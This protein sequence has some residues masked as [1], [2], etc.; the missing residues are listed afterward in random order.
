MKFDKILDAFMFREGTD[1]ETYESM[2]P[3][4]TTGSVVWGV[5]L[6]T[7]IIILLSLFIIEQ[8]DL[9]EYWWLSA[10]AIWAGAAYP[11]WRQYQKFQ[12]KM[13]KFEE[14]TLCGSCRY[15]DTSS[16]LCKIYDEHPTKDYVPC[17]GLNW[18]PK[19]ADNE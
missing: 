13:K 19:E 11:G 1:E 3:V 9:R 17:E 8:F 10:F 6:R 2:Q 12:E 15:L 16:Q 4:I 5:L 14:E 18:E 7:A